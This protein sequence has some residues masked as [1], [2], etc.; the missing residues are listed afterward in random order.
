MMYFFRNNF[1]RR[2][3]C[4]EDAERRA[5]SC[6]QLSNYLRMRFIA[7]YGV[8]SGGVPVFEFDFVVLSLALH[9]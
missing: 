5:V 8:I 1:N 2:K 9:T 6:R 4:A 3:S 7:T